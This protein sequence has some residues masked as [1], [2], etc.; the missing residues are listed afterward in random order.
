[1]RPPKAPLASGVIL[2]ARPDATSY[3]YRLYDRDGDLLYVG[4]TDNLANRLTGHERGPALWWGA[5]HRVEWDLYKTRAEA[6][7]AES[8][9]IEEQVP[10]HN[11]RDNGR[12]V[13]AAQMGH[14]RPYDGEAWRR[15]GAMLRDRRTTM[16]RTQKAVAAD[17]GY[18]VKDYRALE[19]GESKR[20]RKRF[21][22]SVEYTMEWAAGSIERVLAG[23]EPTP[24]TDEQLLARSIETVQRRGHL[25]D[26]L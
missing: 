3:V 24:L 1:M 15:L 7:H 11:L 17:I 13:L 23:R 12:R 18:D 14:R 10:Q 21:L 9:T 22:E 19:H 5:V 6:E 4:V 26:R 8:Y 25:L 2:F 20:Y 16:R